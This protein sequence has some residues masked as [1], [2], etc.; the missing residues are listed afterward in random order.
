MPTQVS[1]P[2]QPSS[3]EQTLTLPG[4]Y[5]WSH[6]KSLQSWSSQ[7]PGLKITYL[8]GV[9]ELMTT[10]KSHERVKKLIAI[11]IEAYC[12]ELGIRFFPSGNATCEAEEK[13][14]SFDPDESY[15]FE[16]DKTYPELAVE[17]VFTSGG[18]EKLEKYRRFDV[19]EVWFWQS[20]RLAIYHL[21]PTTDGNP[22]YQ[23]AD[24]SCWLPD[25]DIALL[26]RC[27]QL[28]EAVEARTQFLTALRSNS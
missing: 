15:C 25:L 2:I 24:R 12:F 10:G 13:G 19:A 14:A 23:L 4:R 16:A 1:L 8:D 11:L 7:T 9:I 3:V 5:P 28:E 20:D 27:T 18:L 22:D 17:V 26:E 6:F 21:T